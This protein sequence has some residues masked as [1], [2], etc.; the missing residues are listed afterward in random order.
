MNDNADS[1]PLILGQ[2]S[3][4]LHDVR[5]VAQQYRKVEL[6]ASAKT[7]IQKTYEYLQKLVAQDR[8]V[9]GLNTGFGPLASVRIPAADILQLQVN[10]LRS[11]A[12]GVGDPLPVNAVRAMMLLRAKSLSLGY[13]GV[14]LTIVQRL[15]DF[16]NHSIHPVVP[17][18]GSV[19]ASGDLAPLAHIARTL[20]GEGKVLYQN[21]VQ[22]SADVL[23]ATGL[24]PVE[25]HAK[26]GLALCNGTQLMTGVGTLAY[27]EAEFLADLADVTGLLSLEAMKGSSAAFDKDLHQQR[28]HPGQRQ[29]ADR[30]RYWLTEIDGKGSEIA[31]SHENCDRVQDAYSLRC[32]PQ[33]HG[34]CRDQLASIRNTLEIEAN[35]VTD[36]PLLFPDQDKVVSGGHFH[37]Q[38]LAF[39]MDQLSMATSELGSISERRINKLT[40]PEFSGLP[41]LLTP[42]PGLNSGVMVLQYA[43]AALVSENKTL[44]H[45]AS[46]DSIPTSLDKE[47]H[48][49]MGAWGARKAAMIVKNVRRILTIEL[50][51]AAQGIDL[52]RPLRT[53]ARLEKVHAWVRTKVPAFVN[54]RCFSEDLEKLDPLLDDEAFRRLISESGKTP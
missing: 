5:S 22:P 41:A 18:Q 21:R 13:S 8:L 3:L 40:Q 50:F 38:V 1:R 11:H 47:D 48:V 54:D 15:L 39:A 2:D 44:S 24:A 53:T 25:L 36:N 23:K 49:S 7:G 35:S 17:S 6:S 31:R 19:G 26:S 43:A 12:A 16:L 51:C 28:P 10:F 52:L 46:V 32:I 27:L 20:I 9:Y 14:S 45:P 4:S 33:V 42:Q 30:G 37:G 34:A 29:V